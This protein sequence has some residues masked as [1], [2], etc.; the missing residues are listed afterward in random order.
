M[1][2]TFVDLYDQ[3]EDQRIETIGKLIM[4]RRSLCG[5]CVDDEPGK[6]ERYVKKVLERFPAIELVDQSKGPVEGV[7]T[8]R[9]RPK[10]V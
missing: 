10:A 2:A 4:S 6:P 7:V 5:V 3:A 1:M 9:F 8:L